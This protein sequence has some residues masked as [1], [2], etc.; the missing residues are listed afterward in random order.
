M[1]RP[2]HWRHVHN[3]VEFNYFKPQG[4]PLSQL[5]EERLDTEELEA[6]RYTEIEE[7]E[8]KEAAHKMNV[9]QPT[10]HRILKNARKKVARALIQGKSIRIQGGKY[11]MPNKDGTG[12]EGKGP[13]TGRGQGKCVSGKDNELDLDRPLRRGRGRNCKRN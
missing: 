4:V 6:L 9:S 11:K 12:P 7:I 10:Y 3:R 5:E 8:Q 13:R 1:V 2:K